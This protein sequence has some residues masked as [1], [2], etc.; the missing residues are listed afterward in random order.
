MKKLKDK[1]HTDKLTLKEILG[2]PLSQEEA[3]T[4]IKSDSDAYTKYLEF[5][6]H[7]K[8]HVLEFIQGNRGLPILYD[9]FFKCPCFLL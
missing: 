5:K 4:L 9:G 6:P 2:N 1:T 8:E 7:E 3:L